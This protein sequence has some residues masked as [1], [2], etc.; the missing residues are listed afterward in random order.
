MTLNTETMPLFAVERRRIVLDLLKTHGRVDNTELSRRFGVTS[1]SV[2]RDLVALEEEGLLVRVH[3]G[4]I[5][6]PSDDAVPDLT[7][8]TAQM[9]KEKR[10]IAASATDLIPASGAVFIDAGST[11]MHMS[12]FLPAHEE[13]TVVTNSLPLASALALRSA[14]TVKVLGGTVRNTLAV[15]GPWALQSLASRH[16]DLA[17]IAT[18]GVSVDH[19]FS[20]PSSAEADIKRAVIRAASKVVVLADHT[21]LGRKY[22]EQIGGIAEIDLLIT[23]AGAPADALNDLIAAG[24]D[25]RVADAAAITNPNGARQP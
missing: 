21:K 22:F 14:P 5:S 20:T 23:D 24:L 7:A 11:T 3:G 1:E 15:V 18:T 16:L 10:W 2:R 8:R 6:R 13:L 17:V 12:E 4:A 25:V 9:V 19:G